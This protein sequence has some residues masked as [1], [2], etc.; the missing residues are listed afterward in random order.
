MLLSTGY[1]LDEAAQRFT[2]SGLAGFLRKPYDADELGGAVKRI[3]GREHKAE[4]N[5]QLDEAMAGLRASYQRKLPEQIETLVETLR[6]A[7]DPA[8]TQAR[9][10]AR[11]LAHRLA[12][13]SGSYGLVRTGAA[14]ERVDSALREMIEQAEGSA[15]TS[16][17]ELWKTIDASMHE[18][19]ELQ[20]N[21]NTDAAD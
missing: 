1:A 7:R 5:E 2:D 3:L 21:W 14:L 17:D 18:L 13:T 9:E 20:A 6:S 4:P 12:G 15:D 10:D 16:S 11:A 8:A 19:S